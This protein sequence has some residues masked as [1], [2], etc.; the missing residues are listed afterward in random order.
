VLSETIWM[1]VRIISLTKQVK[2][3]IVLALIIVT[4]MEN[5]KIASAF[6]NLVG[7]IMIA[8]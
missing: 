1:N 6:A 5:V 3:V 4:D 8:Q 2:L 7:P